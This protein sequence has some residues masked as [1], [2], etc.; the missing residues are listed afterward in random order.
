MYLKTNFEKVDL[1]DKEI[2]SAICSIT[3]EICPFFKDD[4]I[5]C[6][7]CKIGEIC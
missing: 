1:I 6:E 2:V 7:D 4:S 3:K 5:K